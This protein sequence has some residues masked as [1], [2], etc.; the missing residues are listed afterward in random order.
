MP[1]QA[2][3]IKRTAPPPEGYN[4]IEPTIQR[5]LEK[6]RNAQ[7]ESSRG[8]TSKRSSLWPIYQINHQLS[9]YIYEMYYKRALISRDLYEWLLLQKYVNADLIAKWKKQGYEKLC[10]VSCIS[11]SDKN[12]KTTCVCRVP[13][14]T[15]VSHKSSKASS[16]SLDLAQEA[17]DSSDTQ[18]E[19]TTCGCK[20]C[21]STD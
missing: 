5:F 13:R 7:L 18:I 19:C 11:V 4:R 15:L 3:R 1:K 6:L 14:A 2:K 9:R 10:C 21:A 16:G 17:E 20:G 8:G 12:Q